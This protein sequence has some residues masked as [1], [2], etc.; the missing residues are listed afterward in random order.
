MIILEQHWP[1]GVVA[2]LVRVMYVYCV[3]MMD[4]A[5]TGTYAR[6]YAVWMNRC[7][8]FGRVGQTFQ[9]FSK[10]FRGKG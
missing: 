8:G 4:R 2:M 3:C 6:L 10:V 7:R 1:C 9:V 5:S